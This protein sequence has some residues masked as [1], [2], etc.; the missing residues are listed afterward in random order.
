MF[1]FISLAASL[2]NIPSPSIDHW[3]TLRHR[4]LSTRG[5]T[6]NTFTIKSC[7]GNWWLL[8]C[9]Q[10]N[11]AQNQG[12]GLPQDF[13]E[14]IVKASCKFLEKIQ[15]VLRPSCTPGRFHYQFNLRDLT[16]VF[17]VVLLSCL[18]HASTP[19][20]ASSY[21]LS[22][23]FIIRVSRTALRKWELMKII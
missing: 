20:H 5:K 6:A 23:V 19:C 17:Q 3:I 10:A 9:I 16:R 2:C 15:D 13:H 11:M 21:T 4:Q 22:L 1:I 7:A 8:S 18:R 12:M 14:L